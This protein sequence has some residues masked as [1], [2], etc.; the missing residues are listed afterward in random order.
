MGGRIYFIIDGL[1]NFLYVLYL[2]NGNVMYLLR[3]P[4]KF[5]KFSPKFLLYI[6]CKISEHFKVSWVVTNLKYSLN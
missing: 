3:V 6:S 1:E 5:G 2:I 4:I